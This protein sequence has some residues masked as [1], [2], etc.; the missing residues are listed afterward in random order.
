LVLQKQLVD[1]AKSEPA[2]TGR[3]VQAWL[4]EEAQ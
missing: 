2:V 3:L 1:R 4:R